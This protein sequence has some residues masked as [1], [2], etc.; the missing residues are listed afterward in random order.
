M[1]CAGLKAVESTLQAIKNKNSTQRVINLALNM[2]SYA[3]K[4]TWGE[5]EQIIIKIGIHYGPVMAGVIGY[6]KPQFSLIGDTVNTTSRVCSTGEESNITISKYAY[7]KILG[8]Y[9][10]LEFVEK[11]VEAKGK[12]EIITFQ[13]KKKRKTGHN[14]HSTIISPGVLK[15]PKEHEEKVKIDNPTKDSSLASDMNNNDNNNNNNN[16]LI[17]MAKHIRQNIKKT[18]MMMATK[19]VCTSPKHGPSN[20]LHR[21]QSPEKIYSRLTS[22]N[23]LKKKPID[24]HNDNGSVDYAYKSAHINLGS[25]LDNKSEGILSNGF[26]FNRM[27]SALKGFFQDELNSTYE[28]KQS[29]KESFL[30]LNTGI[31]RSDHGHSGGLNIVN[32]IESEHFKALLNSNDVVLDHVDKF[33]QF[34]GQHNQNDVI[35][36]KSGSSNNPIINDD[37]FF[38]KLKVKEN[39]LEILIFHEFWLTLK[40]S[41]PTVIKEFLDKQKEDNFNENMASMGIFNLVYLINTFQVILRKNDT[42]NFEYLL[43]LR[44]V[45]TVLNFISVFIMRK[46]YAETVFMRKLLL[47]LM[48][49]I[50]T[51]ILFEFVLTDYFAMENTLELILFVLISIN[52]SYLSFID[53]LL[54]C[55]YISF[56]LILHSAKQFHLE[57]FINLF[58]VIFCLILILHNLRVKILN[59][60]KN[61]NTLRVNI[62]KKDQQNN[63]IVNLLPTHIL[64]K[65]LRNPNQKLNL[66]DEFE[67]VTILFADIAGF[68]K[69]SSTVSPIQVV[70]VLKDLFTEFDKLCLDNCVYKLY[71]IGDCYV[72]LG[73]ID[74]EERDVERE[75]LN[76][77]NMGFQMIEKIKEV[78]KRVSFHDIDMRIGIHTVYNLF[79]YF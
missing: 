79:Y 57:F 74:A 12:G 10:S 16:E 37:D 36:R 63:L 8:N 32:Y 31:S 24:D 52:Y 14:G 1:A 3:K 68:T 55:I 48:Y 50:T 9:K 65:F 77:I 18:T 61:F 33:E 29:F 58:C 28:K 45:L 41:N 72:V 5:S 42:N 23:N 44:S 69:Y 21:T 22:H 43:S 47:I 39:T 75:A 20:P 64:E 70:S 51:E 4:F 11:R 67:D 73:I 59:V 62:V 34:P 30:K 25:V 49:L 53:N 6:H 27:D 78:K 2:M 40:G 54:L 66:T 38:D 71:T 35:I 15:P 56:F 26:S 76:V 19:A 13:I 7:D 60:Y 46:K 17:K